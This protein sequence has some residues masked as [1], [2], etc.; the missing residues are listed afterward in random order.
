MAFWIGMAI[1]MG[2]IIAI[3]IL[4]GAVVGNKKRRRG[5]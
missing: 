4:G 3:S 2:L 5:E 1:F